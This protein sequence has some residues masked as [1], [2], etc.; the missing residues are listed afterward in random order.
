VDKVDIIWNITRVCPW[1]CAQCCVDAYHVTRDGDTVSVRHSG[2]AETITLSGVGTKQTFDAAAAEMVRRGLEL[3]LEDKLRVVD[4]LAGYDADIDFS[5]GD[6]LVVSENL[7]VIRH[8]SQKFGRENVSITATGA[9]MAQY[10]ADVLA[11]Y[12]HMIE[13]TYDNLGERD[14]TGRPKGYN[15]SN[16]RKAREF[17]RYGCAS[18]AQTPLTP[19][20]MD[21]AVLSRVYL[22]L[23]EAEIDSMLLMR[24]FPVGR[25]A[26]LTRFHVPSRDD[27]RRAIGIVRELQA[28]YG[29]PRV[30]L[31]CALKHVDPAGEGEGNPCDLL[32]ESFGITNDGKLQLS[33]W[34]WDQRGRPLPEWIIGDLTKDAM[35][36]IL[37]S[38]RVA[39]IRA[40]LDDNFGHCKI[41]SY[42]FSGRRGVDSMFERGDPLYVD[43]EQETVPLAVAFSPNGMA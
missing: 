36:D 42:M 39:A 43:A 21:P 22:D 17:K 4:A 20:N 25:A 24:T 19:F 18:K 23:H 11:P 40:R 32:H 38:P 1:D 30:R 8:A 16:L 13:F 35:R 26:D 28:R 14:D 37:A 31:Q 7:D 12:I 3:S 41:F 33:A 34:A 6:P 2:L 10:R 27:Y 29:A 5:G 9:G 15:A